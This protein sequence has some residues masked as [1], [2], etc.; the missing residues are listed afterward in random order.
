[1]ER[2]VGFY[3]DELGMGLRARMGNE[4]G[5]LAAGDYHH[6]VGVNSWQSRGGGPAPPG[7][8]GLERFSIAVPAGEDRDEPI[9]DP[10]GI[11]LRLIAQ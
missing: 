5:F 4:A 10:D 2:S 9:H 3:R 11:E 6:H 8:S 7:S 1:V